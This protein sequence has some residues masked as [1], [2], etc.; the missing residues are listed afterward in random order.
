VN[1]SSSSAGN[2]WRD[3]PG[4]HPTRGATDELERV[5]KKLGNFPPPSVRITQNTLTHLHGIVWTASSTIAPVHS[6]TFDYLARNSR[7][8]IA[9]TR[10]HRQSIRAKWRLR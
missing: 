6:E 7:R 3:Q 1:I 10:R 2:R 4:S 8:A 9:G 5:M